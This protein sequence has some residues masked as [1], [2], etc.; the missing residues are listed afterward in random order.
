[1]P[2][3]I[4][5]LMIRGLFG[6]MRERSV[7]VDPARSAREGP[8]AMLPGLDISIVGQQDPWTDLRARI[9]SEVA[10]EGEA[11]GDA[12]QPPRA[13]TTLPAKCPSCANALEPDPDGEPIAFCYHCGAPLA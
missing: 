13:P 11:E 10:R 12:P 4:A 1:V 9:E 2:T 3:V 5:V 6:A 8:R 7:R